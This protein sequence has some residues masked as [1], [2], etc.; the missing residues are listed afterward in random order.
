[1]RLGRVLTLQDW[2]VLA[3]TAGHSEPEEHHPH[4]DTGALGFVL[5]SS[6][7]LFDRQYTAMICSRFDTM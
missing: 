4:A 2:I 1:M 6:E 3:P 5:H 7:G